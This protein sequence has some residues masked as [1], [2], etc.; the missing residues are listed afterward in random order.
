M[1]AFASRGGASCSTTVP[2]CFTKQSPGNS[3]LPCHECSLSERT[4]SQ[5]M[6]STTTVDANSSFYSLE[7][8]I[9]GKRGFR[10]NCIDS[11]SGGTE[12]EELSATLETG[13]GSGIDF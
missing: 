13:K 2:P 1:R 4:G 3:E 10:P 12:E 6:T 11:S 9:Q 8:F 7:M 5:E